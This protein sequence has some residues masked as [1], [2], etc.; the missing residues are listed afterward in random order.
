[1]AA[2]ARSNITDKEQDQLE[3]ANNDGG[4]PVFKK[5]SADVAVTRVIAK[6]LDGSPEKVAYNTSNRIGSNAGVVYPPSD[7]P[8]RFEDALIGRT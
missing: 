1:M 7:N 3:E 5:N 8:G 4:I 2:V 6:G